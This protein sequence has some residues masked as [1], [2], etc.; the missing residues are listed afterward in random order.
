MKVTVST[1]RARFN[2]FGHVPDEEFGGGPQ[3]SA[4]LGA[5]SVIQTLMALLEVY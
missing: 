3:P 1:F 2:E 5:G 4:G